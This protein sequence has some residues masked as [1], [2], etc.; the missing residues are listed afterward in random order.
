[1]EALIFQHVYAENSLA[2]LKIGDFGESSSASMKRPLS[3]P[4]SLRHSSST[5]LPADIWVLRNTM[6]KSM[7][8][9]ESMQRFVVVV[10]RFGWL[11]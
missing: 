7:D 9:G 10:G 2:E 11:A 6:H 5:T 4:T 1:M 8:G 3:Y